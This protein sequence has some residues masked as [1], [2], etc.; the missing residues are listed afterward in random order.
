M[1]RRVAAAGMP[2]AAFEEMKKV[3]QPCVVAV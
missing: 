2:M 1:L 3:Q